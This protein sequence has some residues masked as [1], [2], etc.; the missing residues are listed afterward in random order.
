MTQDQMD[1]IEVRL[2]HNQTTVKEARILFKEVIRL[3]KLAFQ[4]QKARG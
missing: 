2:E 3:R 1:K 4:M